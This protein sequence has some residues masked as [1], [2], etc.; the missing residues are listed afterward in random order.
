MPDARIQATALRNPNPHYPL[1]NPPSQPLLCHFVMLQFSTWTI[2]WNV[3]KLTVTHSI[4]T[5]DHSGD[6]G[7]IRGQYPNH[8]LAHYGEDIDWDESRMHGG[9]SFRRAPSFNLAIYIANKLL[10]LCPFSLMRSRPPN[11]S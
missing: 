10:S 1:I 5:S 11:T 2:S 4:W 6:K 3:S 8:I 9:E 7:W